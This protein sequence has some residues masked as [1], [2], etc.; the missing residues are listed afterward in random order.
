M[1]FHDD[2]NILYKVDLKKYKY[3][4]SFFT[5]STK[6]F[7]FILSTKKDKHFLQKAISDIG[8]IDQ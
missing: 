6:Y 3:V 7:I 4:C 1:D 8:S 2:L 5:F